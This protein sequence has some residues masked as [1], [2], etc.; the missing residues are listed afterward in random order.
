MIVVRVTISC[1]EKSGYDWLRSDNN[2]V[3]MDCGF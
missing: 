2:A 3:S 1:F